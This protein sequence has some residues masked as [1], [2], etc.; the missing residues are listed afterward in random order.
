LWQGANA[1]TLGTIFGKLSPDQRFPTLSILTRQALFSGGAAPLVNEPLAVLGRFEAASRFGPADAAAK[2]LF[3][4]PRLTADRDLAALAIDAGL[5]AGRTDEACRLIEAVEAP[6]AGTTWLEARATCYALNKEVDAANL[7]VDLAKSRGLT[8][9]WLARAVAATSGPV[10]LPPPFRSD[11][12]RA[13]AL[14]LRAG[15]APPTNPAANAD[16]AA[17]SALIQTPTFFQALPLDAQLALVRAGA[18]RGV[19][20]LNQVEAA[21]T[22]IADAKAAEL[23][24]SLAQA[25]P[26]DIAP[27]DGA[28]PPVPATP[29]AL[30]AP[31]PPSPAD[32]SRA[33]VTAPTLAARVLEARL[34]LPHIKKVM[35]TQPGLMTVADVPILTE[36]ALW[37]GEGALAAAIAALAPDA[38]GPRL[39]LAIALYDPARRSAAID[40][41]VQS[42]AADLAT[43]RLALRDVAL[44]WALGAPDG[45]MHALLLQDGLPWAASGNSGLRTA[46]DLSAARGSKG[47]V[48]LLVALALQ[49]VDPAACDFETLLVAIQALTK[50]GLTTQARDLARD[51]LLA[52]A[53][54]PPKAKP[55]PPKP[56]PAKPAPAKPTSASPLR[57]AQQPL[58][59]ATRIARP[60]WGGS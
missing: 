14:S 58:P 31:A 48:A 22:R 34:A 9:T 7:S 36:A 19:V 28:P 20:P 15:L 49:G 57:G 23:A 37:S 42:G 54:S 16:P 26:A 35:E 40:A 11:S 17:L 45:A 1:L 2:L 25:A 8:D 12:G 21:L 4:V 33:I 38:P 24:A 10:S 44:L 59:N 41:R 50:V 32:L 27:Q 18:M 47:E 30:P 46:L 5:R 60:N 3:G 13:L 53:I 52:G 6:P 29:P 39:M 56:T 51:Y 43:R 55:A